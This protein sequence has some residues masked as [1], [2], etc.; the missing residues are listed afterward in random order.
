[1]K[2]NFHWGNWNCGSKI[3]G[4]SGVV[5]KGRGKWGTLYIQ[6]FSEHL[7]F[8]GWINGKLITSMQP[9][10]IIENSYLYDEISIDSSNLGRD[11]KMVIGDFYLKF[12]GVKIK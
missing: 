8:Q 7:Q 2:E 1:M 9:K 11:S 4:H 3:D 12:K 6:G 5:C 10:L